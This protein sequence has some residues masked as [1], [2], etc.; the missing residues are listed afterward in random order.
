[1][2]VNWPK[3]LATYVLKRDTLL[4]KT[5]ETIFLSYNIGEIQVN[6]PDTSTF[7]DLASQSVQCRLSV[8]LQT[9]GFPVLHPGTLQIKMFGWFLMRAYFSD[10]QMMP[11]LCVPL[12]GRCFYLALCFLMKT[13]LPQQHAKNLLLLEPSCLITSPISTFGHC[14]QIPTSYLQRHISIT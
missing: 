6:Q 2:N 13:N 12:C 1:M 11:L 14:N 5:E 8:R 9:T 10:S 3:V 4:A 7:V